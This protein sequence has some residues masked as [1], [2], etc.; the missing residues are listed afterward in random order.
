MKLHLPRRPDAPAAEPTEGASWSEIGLR[1]TGRLCAA[2][3][4]VLFAVVLVAIHRE[5]LV[6]ASTT[7]LVA[8]LR[9]NNGYFDNRVDFTQPD[10]IRDQV[11]SLEGVLGQIDLAS[12]EDVTLLAATVPDVARL[13]EAGK[14]DLRFAHDL[15]GVAVTLRGSAQDLLRIAEHAN[16]TVDSTDAR[17][18]TALTLVDQL[19]TQLA[20]L[21]GKLAVLSIAP[22]PGRAA[23]L[24]GVL[25]R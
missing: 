22:G 4:A 19:N 16:Q 21:E 9:H 13:L 7:A 1:W 25:P 11:R 6:H 18:R 14:T 24:T 3:A 15:T 20:D 23:R 2:T 10:R 5:R 8:T 17:V 12:G